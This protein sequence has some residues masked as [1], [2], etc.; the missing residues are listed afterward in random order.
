MAAMELTQWIGIAAGIFTASSMLPQLVKTVR[1]KKAQEISVVMLIVLISGVALWIVYGY[2]KDDLP[3]MATNS[4]SLTI[5]LLMIF[6]R[7]RY[8]NN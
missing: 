4:V 2:M 5:N 7:V 1:E 8:R 3:I 6:F